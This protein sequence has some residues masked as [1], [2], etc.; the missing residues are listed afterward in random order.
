MLKEKAYELLEVTA[1]DLKEFGRAAA[2]S[3]WTHTSLA[4]IWTGIIHLCP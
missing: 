1:L 3:R 2:R 4:L